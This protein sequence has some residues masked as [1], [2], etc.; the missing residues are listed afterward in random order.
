M[1]NI[2]TPKITTQKADQLTQITGWIGVACI[3]SAYILVT[4]SLLSPQN[5]AYNILNILG[6]IGILASSYNKRDF[7]PIALNTVWI[8]I[9]VI[10]LVA[11][12]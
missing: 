4:L 5:A 1:T 12:R 10:G 3:L 8:V 9:A 7:Q 6:S 2:T 11:H